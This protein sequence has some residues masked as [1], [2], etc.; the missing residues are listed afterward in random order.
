MTLL[1]F[2]S[3]TNPTRNS[4]TI[5]NGFVRA[6]FKL[7]KQTNVSIDDVHSASPVHRSLLLV[8]CPTAMLV[9][10]VTR[11][12]RPLHQNYL[13]TPLTQKLFLGSP[14]AKIIFRPL[15]MSKSDGEKKKRWTA[16][17]KDDKMF[18]SLKKKI[19]NKTKDQRPFGIRKRRQNLCVFLQKNLS[20]KKEEL[21]F[22]TLMLC[23]LA[24]W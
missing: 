5:Q 16:L 24:I 7:N 10:A 21:F 6:L 9:S 23:R 11:F 13:Y 18:I 8:N 15:L 14:Y 4:V 12:F 2:H 1:R 17:W 22:W 19:L 3:F 20:K